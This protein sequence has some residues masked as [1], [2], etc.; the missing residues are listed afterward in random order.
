MQFEIRRVAS[1]CRL[2]LKYGRLEAATYPAQ[3]PYHDEPLLPYN[4]HCVSSGMI[5]VVMSTCF[6]DMSTVSPEHAC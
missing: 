4:T 6:L 1:A 2:L 3:N 5:E